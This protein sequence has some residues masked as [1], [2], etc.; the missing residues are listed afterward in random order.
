M[1][2]LALILAFSLCVNGF[3][4]SRQKKPMGTKRRSATTSARTTEKPNLK[5]TRK[6]SSAPEAESRATNSE[7]LVAA[8]SFQAVSGTSPSFL[9]SSGFGVQVLSKPGLALQAQMLFSVNKRRTYYVGPDITYALFA[10]G[11]ALTTGAALWYDMRLY[12]SPRLS[13]I[14]GLIAGP[15]FTTS[16]GGFSHT[17]YA[18]LLDLALVQEVDDLISVKGQFR[19]GI[20]GNTFTYVMSFQVA[21]RFL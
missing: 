11:S 15:S 10:P 21:F 6:L 5:P 3:G 9:F 20:L 8:D 4:A 17:T 13:A 1:K 12:G 2:H 19:P 16:L 14:F 18:L 7:A